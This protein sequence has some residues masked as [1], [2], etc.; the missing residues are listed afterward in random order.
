M[1]IVDQFVNYMTSDIPSVRYVE[2]GGPNR[3]V[4]KRID[5]YGFWYASMEKG[6]IANELS[7]A[8]TTFWDAEKAVA[9]YLEKNGKEIRSIK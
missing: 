8:Y 2:T 5:P 7:G 4:L 1:L 6:T 9:A 3:I